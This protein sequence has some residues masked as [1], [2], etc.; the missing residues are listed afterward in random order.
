[1]I[2]I[3]LA[4]DNMLY[5]TDGS[6]NIGE[7]NVELP[8]LIELHETMQKLLNQDEIINVEL[9]DKSVPEIYTMIMEKAYIDIDEHHKLGE[10]AA[11]DSH[12]HRL[13][14][15]FAPSVKQN[16]H[17]AFNKVI[18]DMLQKKFGTEV[19]VEYF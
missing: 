5:V 16:L 4:P 2:E 19:S 18:I 7:L 13:K 12:W 8:D 15:P 3:L 10:M 1:M 6:G 14:R 17:V 9:C 11:N